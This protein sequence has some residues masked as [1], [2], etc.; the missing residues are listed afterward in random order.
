MLFLKQQI[1][2]CCFFPHY[3]AVNNKG[4]ARYDETNERPKA[5]Y[6]PCCSKPNARTRCLAAKRDETWAQLSAL[7]MRV[8][9]IFMP[10]FSVWVFSYFFVLSG[11]V[12]MLV[13]LLKLFAHALTAFSPAISCF[14]LLPLIWCVQLLRNVQPSRNN[15]TH[16]GTQQSKCTSL[17]SMLI[18]TTYRY[19]NDRL[20]FLIHALCC[21][22]LASLF[23]IQFE[24]ICSCFLLRFVLY[25]SSSLRCKISFTLRLGLWA[26]KYV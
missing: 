11:I 9:L 24:W 16:S 5:K 21:S 26:I 13:W 4:N 12:R 1:C 14:F 3:S 8:L 20:A 17:V 10:F 23:R 19:H 22:F 15:E 2:P 18:L 6:Y 25:S 7:E